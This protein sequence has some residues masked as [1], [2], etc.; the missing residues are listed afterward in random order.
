M[1][2]G[3]ALYT[4][5]ERDHPFVECATWADEIKLQGLDLQSHWH[6]VDDPFFDESFIK[7]DWHDETYNVT[8]ALVS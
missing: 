4:T 8:W 3:L 1:L 2:K 7:S 5:Y 6:F